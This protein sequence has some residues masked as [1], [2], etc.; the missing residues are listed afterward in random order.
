MLLSV[1]VQATDPSTL[2]LR[3]EPASGDRPRRLVVSGHL[4]LA[5][6]DRLRAE[7]L[8]VVDDRKEPVVV[9]LDDLASVEGAG[10]AML[11]GLRD[12]LCRSG[13]L[14]TLSGAHG[15]VEAQLALYETGEAGCTIAPP[16]KTVGTLDHIGRATAEIAQSGLLVL[17]FIGD[18]ARSLVALAKNP[19]ESRWRDLPMIAE[20]A[21]ADG[22][23]ITL[24]INFL[25]GLIIA[26][27]AALQMERFGAEI[28]VA[29][30]VGLSITREL[31]PL[32]TAILVAG[33]SG[34]AFAAELGTMRVNEEVDALSALRIDPLAY[35]VV[36]RV[37]ALVLVV[38]ILTLLGDLVGIGGGLVIASFSLDLG[39]E[40]YLRRVAGAV[41]LSDVA[42]GLMKSAAFAGTI[43]LVACQRGLA[44]R[45][46]A[47][48]VGRST[49]SA[50][51]SI[52][53]LLIVLDALFTGLFS[54][55]G[56]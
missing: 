33:R 36:P 51:V 24:L 13:T 25:V 19:R 1:S 22:L 3:R 40:A 32:M 37:L 43:A 20:R 23:P 52:L 5:D 15:E 8:D 7:L 31:G 35:L 48:G 50:V 14:C 30:L 11:I 45:G 4:A 47:T 46:G 2:G 49:T 10:A 55:L 39:W 42:V 34:A 27:Q 56:I 54:A 16:P 38:P 29:D 28:F 12:A 44:T 9:A 53:F 26:L 17:G 41:G 18:L 21:G 6:A